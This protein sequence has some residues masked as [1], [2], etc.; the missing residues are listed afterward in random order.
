VRRTRKGFEFPSIDAVAN[1]HL[2][3]VEPVK[4]V[5]FGHIEGFVVIHAIGIFNDHEV[6]P[7]ASAF[8]SCRHT[9][10]VTHSLKMLTGFL[11]DEDVTV[12]INRNHPTGESSHSTAR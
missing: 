5:Q 9:E 4:D 1:A 6:E 2:D 12:K 11:M 7:S 3:F 8:P 10:F